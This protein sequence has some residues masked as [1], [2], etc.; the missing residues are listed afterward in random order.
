M[1][2]EICISLVRMHHISNPTKFRRLKQHARNSDVS[3]L[4]KKGKP[5]VLVFQG[6]RSS[7]KTF[8]ENARALRYLEWRHVDTRPLISFSAVA[9]G[10]HEVPDMN[11]LIEQLE[12]A[13]LKDWFRTQM[14]MSG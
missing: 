10:L 4:V 6:T 8:L 12:I 14:G 11:S 3:G 7:V 1:S 2:S 9:S 5:G 13:G